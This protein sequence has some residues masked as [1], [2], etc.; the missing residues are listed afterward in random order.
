MF[1]VSFRF[2]LSFRHSNVR[3]RFGAQGGGEFH[4]S[5]AKG[6]GVGMMA[7]C[8]EQW[9]PRHG[10]LFYLWQTHTRHNQT[11][12]PRDNQ[13]GTLGGCRVVTFRRSIRSVVHFSI[14]PYVAPVP[15]ARDQANGKKK[16]GRQTRDALAAESHAEDFRES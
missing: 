1:F 7:C 12:R 14:C 3:I 11:N 4:I 8:A 5:G 13:P 9:P 15:C 16:P 10:I 2:F 6:D